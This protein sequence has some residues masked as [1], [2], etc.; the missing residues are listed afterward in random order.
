M[1]GEQ[2]MAAEEFDALIV[3][4]PND[5]ERLQ[6]NYHRLLAYLPAR[7]VL[8]VGSQDVAC[9][10]R[11]L[12]LGERAGFLDENDIL[13]FDLVHT[14]MED[15]LKEILNGRK[16]PRG[17]TGWYY[18]QFLKMAYARL[19]PDAYYLVWDGDTVP[20]RP[21]SMFQEES[22]IPYLDLKR[23]YHEEYF[24]VM[25]QILPGMKK[26][27]EKSFI[28]EHM[29]I[30]CDIMKRLLND[31]ESNADICGKAFWE[32]V[33]YA[34]D[35]DKLQ[36]NSFSEFETYGTYVVCNCPATYRFRDWHSFRYGGLYFNPD[37]IADRDYQWL[38]QDFYAISFEKGHMV[39][40]DHKNLFDNEKY[41]KKLTARQMLEIAQEEAIEGY[42]EIWD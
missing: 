33:I 16:L 41:Q 17:V 1:E 19:C 32:K 40:E 13:P 18:Q 38:G 42:R 39:R 12:D 11:R 4:T 10:V 8:F 5:F 30:S 14:V 28:S 20:C 35:A 21:F 22:G 31:I 36:S 27:I 23:E 24:H 6:N 29:L 15:A 7:R 3:V 2:N 34:I 37:T 26:S 9:L 25:S